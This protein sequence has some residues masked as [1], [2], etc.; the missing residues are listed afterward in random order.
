VVKVATL[1]EAF[2]A[3]EALGAGG[4]PAELPSC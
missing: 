3:V 4:D 2:D 1:D